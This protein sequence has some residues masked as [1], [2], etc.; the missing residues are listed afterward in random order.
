MTGIINWIKQH[1]EPGIAIIIA[2][3]VIFGVIIISTSL[4]PRYPSTV[5]ELP[6][7]ENISV[8]EICY[9]EI[10]RSVIAATSQGLLLYDL[11]DY[12]YI[13]SLSDQTAFLA[14]THIQGSSRYYA[15]I[16]ENHPT[17]GY[18][19]FQTDDWIDI[20][21]PSMQS[22]NISDIEVAF[23]DGHEIIFLASNRGLFITNETLDPPVKLNT[24]DG[25]LSNQLN[26]LLWYRNT[27]FV[28]SSSGINMIDIRTLKVSNLNHSLHYGSNSP[29]SVESITIQS[30]PNRLFIGT[31]KGLRILS[32]LDDELK[33]ISQPSHPEYLNLNIEALAIDTEHLA[34]FV[35]SENGLAWYD[36][37]SDSWGGS[38]SRRLHLPN[39]EIKC[40]SVFND[41]NHTD[42]YL[43]TLVGLEIIDSSCFDEGRRNGEIWWVDLTR[44]EPSLGLIVAI[45]ALIP[46]WGSLIKTRKKK[47][48]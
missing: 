4:H 1:Q 5:L 16:D 3:S 17:F 33:E 36:L 7:S 46:A 40:V 24:T 42:L 37:S 10:S 2:V 8:R 11:D 9:D 23:I 20:E 27:V 31:T 30:N 18:Y 32:I 14:V 34:L 47:K 15:L 21:Y 28:G 38:L 48:S 44:N 22:C 39:L 45:L 25:L 26:V 43:G 6:T 35:G 13:S 41:C 29:L 19:D 12:S